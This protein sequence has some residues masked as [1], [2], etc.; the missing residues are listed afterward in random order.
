MYALSFL[1]AVH[2]VGALLQTPCS[3]DA[4]GG[5]GKAT[6]LSRKRLTVALEVYSSTAVLRLQ[7][8]Q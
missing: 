5:A 3:N 7:H 4:E 1:L 6:V 8:V 2:V